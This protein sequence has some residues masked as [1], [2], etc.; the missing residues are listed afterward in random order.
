MDHSLVP[1]IP[2]PV[3]PP[4]TKPVFTGRIGEMYGIFIV[5]LLLTIVTIGIYRFWAKVRYRKY[6]WSHVSVAGDSFEYT[7]TGRELFL[8]FLIILFAVILPIVVVSAVAP[9]LLGR[10]HP[11]L[12]GLYQLAFY[13]LILFLIGLGTYAAYR[14]RLSRTLWR[15]IRGGLS[16]SR[17]AYGWRFLGYGVLAFVSCG[18]CVPLMQVRLS[19]YLYNHMEFGTGRFAFQG[20]TWPLFRR[21][22]WIPILYLLLVV[23]IVGTLLAV[24]AIAAG[25][26]SFRPVNPVAVQ[27]AVA[28]HAALLIGAAAVAGV[29]LI[30]IFVAFMRYSAASLRY[31]YSRITFEGLQL[32]YDLSA[33]R[34]FRYGAGNLLILVFTLGL[35]FP[36]V[37]ARM[38]RIA[39]DNL[40][41]VG[42]L[43]FDA[44]GQNTDPRSRFGEGLASAF[45]IGAI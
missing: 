40:T 45:D 15:G 35:G 19:R 26:G 42:T 38:V 31:I 17:S 24:L 36:F 4:E 8:G 33:W 44:I 11:A 1:E 13:G 5:N 41:I 23:T 6:L 30:A 18:F 10:L 16:G 29:L 7:G 32:R 12:L 20:T 2:H 39:T 43:D 34:L 21:F 22:L 27:H 25:N 3:A 9:L 28:A 14:Y 37:L